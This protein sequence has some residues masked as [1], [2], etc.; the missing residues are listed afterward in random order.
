MLFLCWHKYWNGFTGREVQRNCLFVFRKLK[1]KV[2]T[3][4]T[5]ISAVQFVHCYW[6]LFIFVELWMEKR[7]IENK[8]LI[9]RDCLINSWIQNK[10]KYCENW[11]DIKRNGTER[12]KNK[13][14]NKNPKKREMKTKTKTTKEKEWKKRSQT[15]TVP[16]TMVEPNF[17]SNIGEIY[18]EFICS[19][20]CKK[21]NHESSN[22]VDWKK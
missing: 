10:Y 19:G 15:T 22:L 8:K 11:N 4:I 17:Y 1:F 9:P 12:N 5:N 18:T 14:K 20:E 21:K 6:A 2:L 3:E 7:K 13:N 16:T